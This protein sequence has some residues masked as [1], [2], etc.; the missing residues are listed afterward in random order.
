MTDRVLTDLQN[1]VF[2]CLA[3][4]IRP[5]PLKTGNQNLFYKVGWLFE[6]NTEDPIPKT[7]TGFAE[8]FP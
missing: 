1:R 8:T 2:E 5:H 4:G 7:G 6:K 3:R